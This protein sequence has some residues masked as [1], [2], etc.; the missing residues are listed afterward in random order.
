MTKSL[1]ILLLVAHEIWNSAAWRE[2]TH[3]RGRPWE[4]PLYHVDGTPTM[5]QDDAEAVKQMF[6][7]IL[8][9]G[10]ID[11]KGNKLNT[12]DNGRN[13]ETPSS[14]YS[15]VMKKKKKKK[16]TVQKQETVYYLHAFRKG[17]NAWKAWVK[18]AFKGWKLRATIDAWARDEGVDCD[19]LVKRFKS[20]VVCSVRVLVARWN[21]AHK[22]AAR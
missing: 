6:D 13:V 14:S 7:A 4:E 3:V 5:P 22:P 18:R 9:P 15:I 20:R 17:R 19:S 1:A 2:R 12:P 21:S 10:S 8:D 11:S 16:P